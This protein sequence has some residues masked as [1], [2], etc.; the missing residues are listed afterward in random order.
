MLRIPWKMQIGLV[1]C[2][3]AMVAG[4]AAILILWR[5]LQYE[6]YP[7]DVAQYSGMWAGGDLMLE[8]FICG[9]LL[10]MTFVLVLVTYKHE[11][12]YTNY[13]KVVLGVSV[14]LPVSV[15]MIAIP[16][17]S[18]GISLVGWACVFRVFASPMVLM[19]IVMSRLFARFPPAKRI[20][21]Y[22]LL[23]EV[24]TLVGMVLMVA[25]LSHFH[26]A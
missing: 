13:A 14:T 5:Y 16:A 20:T 24:L 8:V 25:G 15:G 3:Y 10:V 1:A 7:A 9:M 17:V 6:E 12:A 26:S 19:G 2:G 18:E 23:I 4:I 22:A 21:N 11:T